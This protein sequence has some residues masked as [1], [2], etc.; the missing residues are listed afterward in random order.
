MSVNNITVNHGTLSTPSVDAT[1][2][3]KTWTYTPAAHY[4]GDV[5]IAYTVSD[6]HGGESALALQHFNITHVNHA[7]TGQDAT[8]TILEDS[9]YVLTPQTFGFSDVDAGDQFN[10]VKINQPAHGT[11]LINNAEPTYDANGVVE[12]SYADIAAG[13]L[14][15]K[16]SL[17][18]NDG[19]INHAIISS[20]PSPYASLTFKVQDS[21]GDAE[22]AWSAVDNHLNIHVTPVND[23]PDGTLLISGTRGANA[24]PITVASYQQ[25]DV[26]TVAATLTDVDS[27]SGAINSDQLSYQWTANGQPIANA[28]APVFELTQAEVGKIIA[29]T[30]RYTDDQGKPEKPEIVTSD[31]T[32][33]ILNVNDSPTGGVVIQHNTTVSAYRQNDVL[34][35]DTHT[36]GD[37]DG[38]G[39]LHYQWVRSAA[40]ATTTSIGSDQPTY[41]LTQ[42]DVGSTVTVTVNYT[43]GQGLSESVTSQ[44]TTEILNVNDA[45]AG[46]PTAT[47]PRG[48]EDTP[49]LINEAD[50]LQ[51]FSDLDG[52]PMSVSTLNV[53][54]KTSLTLEPDRMTI[55][56][57]N[58][59]APVNGVAGITENATVTFFPLAP[60]Q[61]FTFRGI[62]C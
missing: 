24:D 19:L 38:L 17:N 59:V 39:V 44:P 27:E 14:T 10:A 2:G 32:A 45:P 42:A 37:M 4:S 57:T 7:P 9:T 51:G 8:K 1:T 29:V 36:L 11:L 18:E 6:N 25:Y 58:G 61:S 41:T 20:P 50:L 33:A 43:D 16:P 48:V 53:A 40:N 26:L 28:T 35:A 15:F 47:L 21:S 34:T 46:V 12:V 23:N 3:A 13:Q 49:Y 54:Y 52:D 55:A 22:S 60:G 30:A 31:P 62:N 56:I 5:Q